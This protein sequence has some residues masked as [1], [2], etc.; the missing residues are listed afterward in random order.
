MYNKKILQILLGLVIIGFTP[1]AFA[2][3]NL[4]DFLHDDG[5]D[6]NI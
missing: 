4:D 1:Y 2:E 5:D 3:Y 6:Q